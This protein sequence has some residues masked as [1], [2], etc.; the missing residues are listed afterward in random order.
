MTGESQ[1]GAKLI[2]EFLGT[3]VNA[4]DK[5]IATDNTIHVDITTTTTTTTT[6]TNNNNNDN[7][8]DNNTNDNSSNN[9]N[10]TESG[11]KPLRTPKGFSGRSPPP[12]FSIMCLSPGESLV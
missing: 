2:G 9:T 3:R 11:H 12:L 7:D 6:T 10:N 1:L 8:N 4:S 5:D